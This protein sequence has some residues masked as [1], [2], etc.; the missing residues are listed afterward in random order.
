[1]GDSGCGPTA[2]SMVVSDR[3]SKVSPT[4]MAQLASQS[5]FRDETG[6]N[7]GF[8]GYA[9]DVY[10]LQ[11]QDVANP[12]ADYIRNQV[13]NGNSVVLNGYSKNKGSGAFTTAGQSTS[14]KNCG[15]NKRYLN[16][17]KRRRNKK[18]RKTISRSKKEAG[19]N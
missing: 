2:M 18:P 9:G 11:H 5:G 10:G 4:Q 19:S 16:T 6:T 8:I 1:M 13:A 14:K 12:S 17:Q 15:S 7:A 3:N